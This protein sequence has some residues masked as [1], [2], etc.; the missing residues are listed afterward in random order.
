MKRMQ[1]ESELLCVVECDGDAADKADFEH[2][3]VLKHGLRD[4]TNP[5]YEKDAADTC[6]ASAA[7]NHTVNVKEAKAER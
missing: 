3:E 5:G 7:G 6:S 2:L 4:V 1:K